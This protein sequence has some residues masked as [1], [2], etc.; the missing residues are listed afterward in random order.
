MASAEEWF[1]SEDAHGVPDFFGGVCAWLFKPEDVVHG[2]VAWGLGGKESGCADCAAD[3]GVAGVCAVGDFDAFAEGGEADGVVADDVAAADG[4]HSDFALCAFSDCALPSMH[5]VCVDV[6]VSSCADLFGQVEGRAAG[7]VFFEAV[8]GFG[9]FD[10]IVFA[11]D[12][13]DFADEIKEDVDAN[14]GVGCQKYGDACGCRD[15]FGFLFVSETGSA[16][17]AGGFALDAFTEPGKRAGWGGEVYEHVGIL[18]PVGYNGQVEL[19][20]AREFTGV[21]SEHRMARGVERCGDGHV[22]FC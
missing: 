20:D 7:R 2:V 5:E 6:A 12:F 13:G 15:D 21:A 9:N 16:D 19:A 11:E 22:W 1:D 4:V 14:A 18:T 3:K 10:V 8:M 17:E